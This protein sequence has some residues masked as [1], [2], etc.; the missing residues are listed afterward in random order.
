MDVNT[1]LVALSK[2]E[3]TF[4]QYLRSGQYQGGNLGELQDIN[5]HHLALF[6]READLSCMMCRG[7]MMTNVANWYFEQKNKAINEQV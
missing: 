6:G 2:Y 4:N 5:S 1:R 7:E 3:W